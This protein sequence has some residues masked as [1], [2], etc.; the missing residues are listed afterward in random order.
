MDGIKYIFQVVT[1]NEVLRITE[2][3]I[4]RRLIN[5][6]KLTNVEIVSKDQIYFK[7]VV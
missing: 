2:N 4:K 3:E 7:P 5:T 1:E 6:D